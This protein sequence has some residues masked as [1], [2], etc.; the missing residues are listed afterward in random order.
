MPLWVFWLILGLCLLVMEI[1]TAG[2]VI[3]WFGLG[4]LVAALAAFLGLSLPVQ[5]VGFL[6]A[7][8]VLV[9]YTRPLVEKYAFKNKPAIPTNTA[10]LIGR[11]GVVLTDVDNLRGTGLVKVGGEEWSVLSA[12]GTPLSAG[13]TVEITGV[14]GV[15]LMVKPVEK[16]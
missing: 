6:L 1:F 11:Q 2:F 16:L 4:A 13:T 12:D 3:M 5:I 8:F 14:Q 9:V 10:A 7:T 15:R